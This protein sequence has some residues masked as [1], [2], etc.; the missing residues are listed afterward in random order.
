M[1][2]C[3]RAHKRP[4]AALISPPCTE[5]SPLQNLAKRTPVLKH[6]FKQRLRRTRPIFRNS[7]LLSLQFLTKRIHVIGEQ[8]LRC[9]SWTQTEWKDLDA[10]LP[11]TRTVLGCRVGLRAPDCGK[12]MSKAWMFKTSST[13]VAD[14]LSGLDVCTHTYKH[15]TC[16]GKVRTDWSKFYT[17]ELA[18]LLVDA[19]K[20][21]PATDVAAEHMRKDARATL[22][23]K[24]ANSVYAPLRVYAQKHLKTFR[25]RRW[26]RR[27]WAQS[28][29][30]RT[31]RKNIR[32]SV[33]A[34]VP[35]TIAPTYRRC[36]SY[37]KGCAG[38]AAQSAFAY[39]AR[40][41]R[42][43]LTKFG[44]RKALCKFCLRQFAV[45]HC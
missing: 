21:I 22:P 5:R 23:K 1:K 38:G 26:Y 28:S 24:Q 9:R 18:C 19:V 6:K 36:V 45:R 42:A 37:A 7:Y 29:R 10:V 34:K 30:H 25:G 39:S 2:C 13:H 4:T 20:T 11:F 8:P 16:I 33:L 43:V 15:V 14:A 44:K 17:D 3:Y 32:L 12:L 31:V 35:R 40:C 41:Q 27:H